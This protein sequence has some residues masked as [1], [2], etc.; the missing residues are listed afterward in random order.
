MGVATWVGIIVVAAVVSVLLGLFFSPE[1][2]ERRERRKA[3][4]L[5]RRAAL[6]EH[7]LESKPG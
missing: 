6:D 1:R 2:I 3:R 5:D 4:R 7:D